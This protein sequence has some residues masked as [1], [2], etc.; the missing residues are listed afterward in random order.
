MS[1]KPHVLD[2]ISIE[3]LFTYYTIY[4]TSQPEN[5]RN[6]HCGPRPFFFFVEPV[7]ANQLY[8]GSPGPS[9]PM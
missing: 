8:M 3:F 9:V 2:D 7:P 5:A 4:H 6:S 1:Q